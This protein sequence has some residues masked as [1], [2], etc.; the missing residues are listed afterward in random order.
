MI[1]LSLGPLQPPPLFPLPLH[2]LGVMD[3]ASHWGFFDFPAERKPDVQ[4]ARRSAEDPL[5]GERTEN[6]LME[7]TLTILMGF[8]LK[9]LL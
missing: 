9:R 2:L 1:Y 4:A 8:S 6:R 3:V 5:R 7:T